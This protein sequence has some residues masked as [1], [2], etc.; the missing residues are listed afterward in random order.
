M[1]KL[2]FVNAYSQEILREVDYDSTDHIKS[3][4]DSMEKRD[5]KLGMFLLD[6]KM[7]TLKAEYVSFSKIHK[8]KSTTYK[9]YFKVKLNDIQAMVKQVK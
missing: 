6:S 2:Q 7:R 9:L 3:I 1:Y 8:S 5:S 4:I